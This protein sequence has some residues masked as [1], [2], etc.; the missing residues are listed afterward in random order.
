M[1][2][3]TARRSET[4]S[5]ENPPGIVR[6]TIAYNDQMM[7]C[8]FTLAKDAK[9]PIH[10]HIAVQNGYLIKGKIRMVWESG[11]EFVA[12]PGDGWCFESN[13]VHRA[14]ILEDSEAIE[15]FSP[16]RPEYEPKQ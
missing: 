5:V 9:I 8:H 15:C 16:M 2:R 11:K 10:K 4:K 6:T 12:G 13:E 14:E 3:V 1:S 7:L